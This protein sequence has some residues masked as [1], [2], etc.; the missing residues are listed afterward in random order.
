MERSYP[1][2]AKLAAVVLVAAVCTLLFT[3][4]VH[5]R[6]RHAAAQS[7]GTASPTNSPTSSPSATATS[8][9]T[10]VVPPTATSPAA[11]STPAPGSGAIVAA[12]PAGSTSLPKESLG[13]G[14][15]AGTVIV[16]NPGGANEERVTIV[17]IGGTVVLSA[18]TKFAHAAGERIVTV[19]P[20]PPAT[21]TG[22]EL[23]G[24]LLRMELIVVAGIALV[25]TFSVIAARRRR[26]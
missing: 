12:L 24:S 7:Y 1:F 19:A 22:P 13:S 23:D 18:P 17:S 6:L 8:V 16:I 25:V 10:T 9:P 3:G 2:V 20:A 14:F 21:G 15:A 26:T 5:D 11:T 4:N